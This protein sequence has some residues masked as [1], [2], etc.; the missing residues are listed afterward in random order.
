MTSRW[1]MRRSGR[2][3]IWHRR[4]NSGRRNR[5]VNGAALLRMAAASIVGTLDSTFIRS[6]ES[7]ERRLEIRVGIRLQHLKQVAN[8]LPC[9]DPSRATAKAVI[10]AAAVERQSRQRPDQHR[11]HPRGRASF[12][13]EPGTRKSIAPAR[14]LWT[15]LHA[16]D[17]YLIGQS[18]WLVNYAERHPGAPRV[19]TALSEGTANVLFSGRMKVSPADAV[20]ATWRRSAAPG[21]LCRP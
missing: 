3:Q 13:G 4:G 18:N 10:V 14:M 12:R 21:S 15:A 1:N 20:V 7:G 2:L 6:C 5:H 11:P 8:G 17:G 19:G 16:L 9:D